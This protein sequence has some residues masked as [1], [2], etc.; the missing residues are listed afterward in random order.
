MYTHGSGEWCGLELCLT[1][2]VHWNTLKARL[3]RK[4]R[5]VTSPAAGR[6]V[7]PEVP[8]KK[9]SLLNKSRETK[10]IAEK[11]TFDPKQY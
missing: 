3:A 9:I 2:W 1:Y 7:K 10:S 11:K 4:S 5:A 8:K 6:K